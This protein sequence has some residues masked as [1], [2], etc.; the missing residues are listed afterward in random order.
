MK[1]LPYPTS[2]DKQVVSSCEV[3]TKMKAKFYHPKENTLIKATQP[4]EYLNLNFKSPISLF[5]SKNYLLIVVD[6][7]LHF[8]FTFPC[9]NTALSNVIKCVKKTVHFYWHAKLYIY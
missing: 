5:N 7:F 8:P 6:E 4:M 2:N 1:N 3:C 9:K